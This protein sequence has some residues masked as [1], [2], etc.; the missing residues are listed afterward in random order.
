ME[1]PRPTS[2]PDDDRIAKHEDRERAPLDD[3][4]APIA[5][6]PGK[7]LSGLS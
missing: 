1:R 2:L 7:P 4:L 6:R 3:T 5:A